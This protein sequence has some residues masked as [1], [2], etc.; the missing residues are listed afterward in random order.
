[1]KVSQWVIGLLAL[2]CVTSIAS[3]GRAEEATDTGYGA[4]IVDPS[5]GDVIGHVRQTPNSDVI[6]GGAFLFTG[7]Y[8]FSAVV[9]G[10]S[11]IRADERLWIP[12]A[13]PWMDLAERPGCGAR[14][15]A[16]SCDNEPVNRA[17]LVTSGIVQGVGVLQMLGGFMFPK[18]EVVML[19]G[20]R[21]VHV[22]PTA[23]GSAVGLTA[24]GAF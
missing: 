15:R 12:V 13:G 2:P 5:S 19:E 16:P 1:M 10:T 18:T 21:G 11:D 7:A 14:A 3:T 4:A 23:A 20:R 24:V 22:V 9:A 17:L 6:V 8:S